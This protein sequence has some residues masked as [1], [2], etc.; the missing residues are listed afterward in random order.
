MKEITAPG[1]LRSSTS[2]ETCSEHARLPAV[3]S[4]I[5]YGATAALAIHARAGLWHLR[6][7]RNPQPGP[8][9][10]CSCTLRMVSPSLTELL[11]RKQ[12]R[13]RKTHAPAAR[14]ASYALE[15]ATSMSYAA[16]SSRSEQLQAVRR[17]TAC[18]ERPRNFRRATHRAGRSAFARTQLLNRADAETFLRQPPRGETP[19]LVRKTVAG[20]KALDPARRLS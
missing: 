16:R 11:R 7:P 6:R 15:S 19:Q 13:S 3:R 8:C 2:D 9:S 1:A 4:V 12:S 17:H 18:R 14:V 20:Q 5:Y 10:A